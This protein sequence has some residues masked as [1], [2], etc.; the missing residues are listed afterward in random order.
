MPMV[1]TGFT[2]GWLVRCCLESD[3]WGCCMDEVY[4]EG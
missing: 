2:A 3:F 4:E 1:I